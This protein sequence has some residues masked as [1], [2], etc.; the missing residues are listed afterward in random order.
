[1]DGQAKEKRTKR[2]PLLNTF[3]GMD[4]VVPKEQ[5]RRELVRSKCQREDLR[6]LFQNCM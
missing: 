3:C 4:N 6:G 1:M 2:V 5:K